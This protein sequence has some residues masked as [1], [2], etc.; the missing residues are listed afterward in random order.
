P[1][2]G[3][4]ADALAV[5]TLTGTLAAEAL[6]MPALAA[7][8]VDELWAVLTA[9]SADA[10][11]ATLAL[12]HALDWAAANQG[13]FYGRGHAEG[14]PY[15]PARAESPSAGGA[16]GWDRDEVLSPFRGGFTPA[17]LKKLL[18]EAGYE[19][20]AVVSPWRARG[21]LKV[22]SSARARLH[23]QALLDKEKP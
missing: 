1:V 21:W 8:P 17:G 2:V 15:S 13:L 14:G 20:D 6:G 12:S 5:V 3:R 4:L 22:D 7:T 10:D 9:E 18:E 19:Y 23:H 16:G 11:R